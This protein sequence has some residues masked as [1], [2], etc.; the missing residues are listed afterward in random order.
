MQ[1]TRVYKQENSSMG[2]TIDRKRTTKVATEKISELLERNDYT[3]AL[4]LASIY[5]HMRLRTLITLRLNP[6]QENWRDISNSFNSSLSPLGYNSLLNVC[7][8]LHLVTVEDKNNLKRIWALR[9]SI[10]H[11]TGLWKALSK[12]KKTE[13]NR[14][15]KHAAEFLRSTNR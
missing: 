11:E 3:S 13:I 7:G 14:L 5:V 9:N 6:P 10:A 12:K 2:L 1:T 15:C 4:L 8:K